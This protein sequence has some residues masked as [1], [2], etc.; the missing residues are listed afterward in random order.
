MV[1]Q[2]DYIYFVYGLSMA[3]LI[4]TVWRLALGKEERLPWMLFVWFGLLHGANEWLDMP[5]LVLGDSTEFNRAGPFV[6]V[7]AP[8]E[9][10]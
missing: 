3:M 4:V 7:R 5:A 8:W 6:T 9:S 1:R 10:G 2:L